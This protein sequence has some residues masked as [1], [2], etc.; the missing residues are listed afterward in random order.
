MFSYIPRRL[1][2]AVPVMLVSSI[3]AFLFIHAV[4]GD[5]VQVMLGP[6]YDPQLATHIKQNL[7]LDEPLVVQ[8]YKWISNAMRGNL[9]RSYIFQAM[10]TDL[11]LDRAPTTMILAVGATLVG[12]LIGVPA[13]IVSA[14][15]KNTLFDSLSRVISMIGVSMPVF[16]IGLLLLIWVALRVDFFPTS[17][18]IEEYGLRSMILPCF[19]L[20]I[21][22]S[23]LIMRITRSSMLEESTMDYVVTARAKGLHENVVIYKH[24]LKNAISPVITIVGLQLGFLLGG[25]VLTETIFNLPG[26]GRLF[27]DAIHSLDYPVVQACFLVFVVV[28]VVVNLVVDI[29]YAII[30]PRI[31]L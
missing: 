17:G 29:C 16:W 12:L 9:G 21:T 22:M 27:V 30:D 15:R 20:G 19:S 18:G 23:A 7:G 5:P 4:P 31:K 28:F 13:G 10:V 25:A 8:Y 26:L 14:T 1:V 11:F 6:D 3:L 24:T 2:L